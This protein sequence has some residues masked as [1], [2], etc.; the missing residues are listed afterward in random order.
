MAA[1]VYLDPQNNGVDE[2]FS[3]VEHQNVDVALFVDESVRLEVTRGDSSLI[4]LAGSE[5]DVVNPSSTSDY[6]AGRLGNDMIDGGAGDDA[7]YGGDGDDIL[8]GGSG[9]DT[10]SGGNGDDSLVYDPLDVLNG[11]LGLDTLM[12][13]DSIDFTGL[14]G[15]LNLL[16]G[17]EKVDLTNAVPNTITMAIDNL[18]DWVADNALDSFIADGKSK[19]A[20]T[21]DASDQIILDGQDLSNITGNTLMNGVTSDFIELNDPIG[22]GN[23]YISFFNVANTAHLLVN[24][25]LV[26]PDPMG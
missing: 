6:L 20:I 5:D 26:D 1:S 17:F 19:I 8:S 21:G 4:L 23:N 7:I 9:V 14:G 10:V 3:V 22:D 24:S 15:M 13:A 16:S 11:D 18:I 25:L 2:H 12:L